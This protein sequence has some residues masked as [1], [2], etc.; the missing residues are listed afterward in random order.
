MSKNTPGTR[1]GPGGRERTECD[2]IVYR[3]GLMVCVVYIYILMV[4]VVCQTVYNIYIYIIYR[5]MDREREV[6]N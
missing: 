3:S 6:T 4:C 5:G 2:R 1:V